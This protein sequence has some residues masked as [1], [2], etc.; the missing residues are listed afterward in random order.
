M[1]HLSVYF[2][3]FLICLSPLTKSLPFLRPAHAVTVETN[4][5]A[6]NTETTADSDADGISNTAE[7]QNLTDPEASTDTDADSVPDYLE[8]NNTD[9]DQDGLTNNVDANDDGDGTTTIEENQTGSSVTI[10]T[11]GDTT[12]PDADAD[13]VPDYLESNTIDTDHDGI[14]DSADPDDDGD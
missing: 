14:V 1:K 4:T 5:A 11:S 12:S 10:S 7:G 6:G 3:S 8:P 13:S 2:I 9:T